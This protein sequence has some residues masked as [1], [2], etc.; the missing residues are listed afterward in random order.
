[1]G[2]R[3]S[4]EK[5][6]LGFFEK[7]PHVILIVLFGSYAQGQASEQSD[8]DVAVLFD[9]SHVPQSGSLIE[10]RE[11]LSAVLEKDVDLVCLNTTSPILGMQVHNHGKDLSVKNPMER[12]RYEMRLFKEYA[13]LKELRAPMEKD[14]LKRKLYD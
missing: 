13:E 12:D 9:R 10:W 14:I 1:M 3:S 2:E 7:I 11:D 8:V 5:K 6:I 4:L